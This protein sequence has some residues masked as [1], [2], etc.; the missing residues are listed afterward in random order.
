MKVLTV[1][2]W[3]QFKRLFPIFY[4][5]LFLCWALPKVMGVIMGVMIRFRASLRVGVRAGLGLG[6]GF[7]LCLELRLLARCRLRLGVCL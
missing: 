3:Q 2:R 6:L 7:G 4:L 5:G 1:R